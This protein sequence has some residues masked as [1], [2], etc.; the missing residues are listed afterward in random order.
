MEVC[1]KPTV[2]ERRL[3]SMRDNA[4][5]LRLADRAEAILRSDRKSFLQNQR[6]Q[7][8]PAVLLALVPDIGGVI[9]LMDAY[10][11]EIAENAG[12]QYIRLISTDMRELP[13]AVLERTL[14]VLADVTGRDESVVTL[15]YQALALGRRVLL[16]AQNP[17]DLPPALG[18]A[19]HSVLYNQEEGQFG[20]LIQSIRSLAF[21]ALDEK[22]TADERDHVHPR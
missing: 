15:V 4:Q 14:L 16:S 13:R 1:P 3:Q 17:A 11:P 21:S 20:P 18:D 5:K 9:D 7:Q 12:L 6:Q 10:I 22:T 19:V 2:L 8:L